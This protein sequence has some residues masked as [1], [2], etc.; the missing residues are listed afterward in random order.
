MINMNE[1]KIMGVLKEQKIVFKKLEVLEEAFPM[2]T[3]KNI[4]LINSI[5]TKIKDLNLKNLIISGI[6]SKETLFFQRHVLPDMYKKLF[7]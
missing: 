5:R 4:T 2:P 1:L 3:L 7:I 6:L